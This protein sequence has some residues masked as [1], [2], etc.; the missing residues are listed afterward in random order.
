MPLNRRGAAWSRDAK[1]R[2]PRLPSVRTY[3]W[4]WSAAT[5][6]STRTGKRRPLPASLARRG[7]ITRTASGD[8]PVAWPILRA[9]PSRTGISSFAPE[10]RSEEGAFERLR[11]G[12]SSWVSSILIECPFGNCQPFPWSSNSVV[13]FAVVTRRSPR[14][15]ITSVPSGKTS[16]IR[17]FSWMSWPWPVCGTVTRVRPSIV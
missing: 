15:T 2:Q 8:E 17:A 1:S 4:K 6:P 11:Y 9:G 3:S 14:S 16:Y 7:A 5:L 12:S 10:R 13:S